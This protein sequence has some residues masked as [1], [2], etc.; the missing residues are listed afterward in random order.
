MASKSPIRVKIGDFGLAKLARDGTAFRTQGGTRDYVA[1]EAGIDISSETSEYTNAIDIWALGCITHEMLTQT[2]PFWGLREL[3]SYCSH[4]QLP[5]NTMHSKNISK[6]GIEFVER[7][8]GYP[9]ERRIKARE[10][11]DLE[12]LRLEDNGMAG[13]GIEGGR[14]GQ[15]LPEIPGP[16]R[17]EIANGGSPP[18]GGM[19]AVL[20]AWANKVLKAV[21]RPPAAKEGNMNQG[22]EWERGREGVRGREPG[23]ELEHWGCCG[24]GGHCPDHGYWLVATTPICL[25]CEHKRCGRCRVQRIIG[26]E[27]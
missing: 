27:N 19:G 26:H 13:L 25:S 2:L 16:S 1:P 12:W 8:L 7:A 17:G 23:L 14:D 10:A 3:S 24:N 5:R 20:T 15:V 9:P 6:G 18:P 11:L 22:M 21:K 4:P